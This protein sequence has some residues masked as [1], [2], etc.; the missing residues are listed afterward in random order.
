MKFWKTLFF[1]VLFE[2]CPFN[3][4]SNERSYELVDKDKYPESGVLQ[5]FEDV[6]SPAQ[7]GVLVHGAPE[8]FY[9]KFLNVCLSTEQGP[10]SSLMAAPG[11][12]HYRLAS[13]T[14]YGTSTNEP[15]ISTGHHTLDKENTTSNEPVTYDLDTSTVHQ[16]DGTSINE[17]E[18]S[19]GQHTLDKENTTPSELVTNE[20]DTSTV[21]QTVC[22]GG[23]SPY[24]SHCYFFSTSKMSWDK[25]KVECEAHASYLVE[26]DDLNENRWLSYN[27]LETIDGVS[28]SDVFACSAWI[29]ASDLISEGV[30][31]WTRQNRLVTLAFWGPL[32][33]NDVLSF[34]TTEDCVSMLQG[35]F[36]DDIS[37]ADANNFICEK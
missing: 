16:T 26:V 15:E 3:L 23:W 21:Q 35:G 18:I 34:P 7:C 8:Y 13:E 37:C 14:F 27:F 2:V 36:W 20:L 9:N 19:T 24:G 29:G 17:L 4:A 31:S 30:F 5:T 33:P 12:Y 11:F 22:E 6:H 25:A 28:C 10:Q 1:G 32:Q